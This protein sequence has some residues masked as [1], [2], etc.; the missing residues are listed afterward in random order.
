MGPKNWVEELPLVFIASGVGPNHS[1]HAGPTKLASTVAILDVQILTATRVSQSLCRSGFVSAGHAKGMA[2]T[3]LYDC[4]RKNHLKKLW[5]EQFLQGLTLSQSHQP[6][7]LQST[8]SIG[9]YGRKFACPWH[10]SCLLE[11]PSSQQF[12]T[13]LLPHNEASQLC[14]SW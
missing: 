14:Q 4:P 8:W 7:A 2:W 5:W 10:G 6:A 12:T 11:T 13:V 9:W 1:V 3:G